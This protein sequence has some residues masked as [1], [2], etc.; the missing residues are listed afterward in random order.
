MEGRLEEMLR[1][2]MNSLVCTV[3][4]AIDEA[5]PLACEQLDLIV[6]GLEFVQ[7][8]INGYA[9]FESGRLQIQTR[10]ARALALLSLPVAPPT[11]ELSRVLA[12]LDSAPRLPTEIRSASDALAS[13]VTELLHH[14]KDS[15][16]AC[17]TRAGQ[18]VLEHGASLAAW[19]SAWYGASPSLAGD[20]AASPDPAYRTGPAS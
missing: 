13:A 14:L 11:S 1:A 10:L 19:E 3:K 5:D 2:A 18:L 7:R 8:R 4:P 12:A 9:A 17:L 20:A 6:E 16:D 15:N